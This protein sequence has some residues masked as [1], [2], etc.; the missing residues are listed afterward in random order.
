[1]TVPIQAPQYSVEPPAPYAVVRPP[2]T[3][4]EKKGAFWAGA[5]GFNLLTL[6]FT[7]VIM[8]IMIGFFGAFFSVLMNVAAGDSGEQGT[9]FLAMLGVM[10]S[11]DVGFVVI[12]GVAIVLI[13]LAIMTGAI[14][15]SRSILRSHGV[16]RPRAVTW[17]GAGIAIAGSWIVG[18][19]PGF[20]VPFAT[21][22]FASMGMDGTTTAIS[23]GLL[24]VIL[25]IAF[26]GVIGWLSWWWMS[27]VFRPALRID[28]ASAVNIQE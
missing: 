3:P 27:H 17:S 20:I 15:L 14:F 1:M 2:L 16:N 26:A 24:G 5:V 4:R 19:I 7:L 22:P 12:I 25:G 21:G 13:G 23:G 9:G 18:W 10:R 8:P 6:G 11:I 28:A